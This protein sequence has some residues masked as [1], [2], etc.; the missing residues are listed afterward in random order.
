LP[1]EIDITGILTA[2][3]RPS[4]LLILLV[5]SCLVWIGIISCGIMLL[6]GNGFSVGWIVAGVLLLAT[7]IWVVVMFRE[8][9]NAVEIPE[10]R[11]PVEA[12]ASRSVPLHYN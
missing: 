12:D 5:F 9:R 11:P 6:V 3:F 2:P 10:Y 4:K 1:T 7:L 8:F